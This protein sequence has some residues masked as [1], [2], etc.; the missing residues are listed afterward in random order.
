MNT[1]YIILII[2]GYIL[3]SAVT[4]L[5]LNRTTEPEK[6]LCILGGIV[7]PLTAI[8]AICAAGLWVVVNGIEWLAKK[9][10]EA[11]KRHKI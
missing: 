2:I 1:I 8:W 11:E 4:A 9:W 10:E 5:I 3:L 6:E 7:W